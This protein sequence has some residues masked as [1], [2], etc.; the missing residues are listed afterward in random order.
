M[1]SSFMVEVIDIVFGYKI[2]D[3]FFLLTISFLSMSIFAVKNV[4]NGK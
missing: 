4:Y 1:K 3:F 2:I